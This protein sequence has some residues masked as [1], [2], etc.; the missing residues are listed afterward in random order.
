MRTVKEKVTFG[1]SA[2]I[3]LLFNIRLDGYPNP[4][5]QG[6][7]VQTLIN[8]LETVPFVAGTTFIL[9]SFLQYMIG[10]EK[11]PWDRRLRLFFL[12]GIM[13]GLIMA[14]YEYAGPPA[15]GL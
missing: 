8:L 11:L 14:I 5:F 3:Y 2:A 10:G 4:T 1:V 13:G 15:T 7:L 12:V 9:I 6:S